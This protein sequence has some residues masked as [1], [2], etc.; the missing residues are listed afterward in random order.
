MLRRSSSL[1]FIATLSLAAACTSPA[2]EGEAEGET[3]SDELSHAE[4]IQPIW[5]ANCVS[6]CHQPGGIASFLD[7]TDGHAA[8]VDVASLEAAGVDWVEPGSAADS[9]VVAKLRGTQMDAGG[10]GGQMPLNGTPLDEA[11]ITMIEE[12][13]DAGAPP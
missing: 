4:D 10:S 12:W 2:E 3:G 1:L 5:D 11:T 8:M 9:Y 13:I 7:L 6:M